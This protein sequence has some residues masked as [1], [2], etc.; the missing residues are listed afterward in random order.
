M[1][2]VE[3]DRRNIAASDEHELILRPSIPVSAHSIADERQE[4]AKAA[5]LLPAA[6]A[7]ERA[8][9]IVP[10][11]LNY[12]PFNPPPWPSFI[13]L[14]A[15]NQILDTSA[16]GFFAERM[17]TVNNEGI[18]ARVTVPAGRPQ[19]FRVLNA[20]PNGP[21]YI[22][23]RDASGNVQQMHIV[24]RDGVPISVDE[25]HPFARY[26]AMDGLLLGPS[27]RADILVTL[28]QGQTLTL[29]SDRYCFGGFGAIMSKRDVLTIEAGLPSQSNP[30][31][32]I[33]SAP[34][35]ADDTR[36][37]ELVRY[38]HSHSRLVRRRAITFTQYVLPNAD[39]KGAHPEFYITQTSNRDFHEQPYWPAFVPGQN[40]PSHADIVVK[41][42]SIEEWYLFN[43]TVEQH[44][45]HIH[46][47]AFAAEDERP[48]PVMLDTVMIPLGTMLPNPGNPNFPLIKPSV[49]RILLDFRHVPRGEFVYH[50]HMLLH[51]DNG[52][53]G[54][55]RVE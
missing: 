33:V 50:C 32:A 12:N 19:L 20:L 34:V 27:M 15:G 47:M 21:K 31:T 25:A 51:E 44:A 3:P 16:C 24:G 52:M 39:G 46:Q 4:V 55:I 17:F 5:A 11:L 18:P 28:Q 26:V 13:P 10:P 38:A 7:Y 8:L 36:A 30:K 37:M 23:L 40:A 14:R 45:F 6:G 54:I 9:R 42:G 22:R 29:Y 35:S 1:W 43:A 49:T 2:I 53:M 41:Q 48:M